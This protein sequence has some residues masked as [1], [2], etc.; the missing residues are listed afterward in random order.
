MT[1]LKIDSSKRIDDNNM[2]FRQKLN[3]SVELHIG[4]EICTVLCYRHLKEKVCSFHTHCQAVQE[5]GC[6]KLEKMERFH[7]QLLC[8]LLLH[9][10]E[11]F[12]ETVTAAPDA[13]FHSVGS[14]RLNIPYHFYHCHL[15]SPSCLNL[16]HFIPPL[17]PMKRFFY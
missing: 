6:H 10:P 1:K 7:L 15:I 16:F 4:P 17:P 11:C 5:S 13:V 9:S 14:F 2:Q 3:C 8:F 12:Y